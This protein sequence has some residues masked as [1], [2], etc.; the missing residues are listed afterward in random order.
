MDRVDDGGV[1]LDSPASA[2]PDRRHAAPC[3]DGTHLFECQC[4]EDRRE[5]YEMLLDHLRRSPD[6]PP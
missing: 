2:H 4:A 3:P 1:E 5:L 6:H